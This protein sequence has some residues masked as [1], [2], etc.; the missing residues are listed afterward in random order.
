[1]NDEDLDPEERKET[2][3]LPLTQDLLMNRPSI[4]KLSAFRN[5]PPA[6]MAQS[7]QGDF[8]TT[9]RDRDDSSEMQAIDMEVTDFEKHL[10]QK[11]I[12]RSV[13]NKDKLNWSS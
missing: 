8:E 6:V 2:E 7:S 12:R 10:T 3:Q 1:L 13:V 5:G 4:S 11:S 9:Q